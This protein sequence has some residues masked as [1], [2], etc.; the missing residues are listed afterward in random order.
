MWSSWFLDCEDSVRC[1]VDSW[2]STIQS[3]IVLHLFMANLR[4]CLRFRDAWLTFTRHRGSHRSF[5]FSSCNFVNFWVS[6]YVWIKK[7]NSSQSSSIVELRFLF[8]PFLFLSILSSFTNFRP[9]FWPYM[10]WSGSC[11]RHFYLDFRFL[12]IHATSFLVLMSPRS[13]LHFFLLLEFPCLSQYPAMKM[14]G[15]ASEDEVEELVDRPEKTN[16][17]QFA[18]LQLFFFTFFG[19]MWFLTA[20]PVV[21]T[22]MI[23]AELPE[24]NRWPSSPSFDSSMSW[25]SQ[26]RQN[27]GLSCWPYAYWLRNPGVPILPRASRM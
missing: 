24:W 27:S 15:E 10:I 23:L 20:G 13:P 8:C 6:S 22:P 9:I 16:G 18:I 17:T 14:W 2:D 19:E 11:C 12:L 25:W 1:L 7:R 21:C 5:Q 3:Y 26:T 4:L